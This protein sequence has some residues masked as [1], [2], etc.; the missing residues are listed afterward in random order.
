M[1]NM[2]VNKMSRLFWL[3][4]Y[5]ERISS[6]I[7]YLW[8]W[9]DKMIDGK[10]L[11]YPAFCKALEIKC[12]YESVEDFMQSYVFDGSNPDSLRSAAD[13]MLGN[14]MMLRETIGSRTLAYLELA[15]N[16]F[17]TGKDS[18]TPTLPLQR[19]IDCIMA[20]R[21]SYDDRI[22]DENV[23]NIIKCG[24]GI[25]RL[26]LYLRLNLRTDR[27]HSEVLR[28][29][30]QINQTSLVPSQEALRVLLKVQPEIS[31]EEHG[32]ILAATEN[33]FSL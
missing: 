26:S 19:V 13:T 14:G 29:V 17:E 30:K 15:V 6:T 7:S 3:G 24:A 33:L 28:L 32:V 25:E 31:P 23:R 12:D 20:F 2:S 5:Y 16:A 21:G 8:S 10:P 22:D 18:V 11:D 9:Y 4:R 27:I 1:D